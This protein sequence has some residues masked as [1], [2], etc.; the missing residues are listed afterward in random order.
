MTTL[1][2][3]KAVAAFDKVK[4]A[5]D[6]LRSEYGQID[7]AIAK[8][9]T[10]MAALPQM[11]VPFEDMKQGILELIDTAGKR[12]AEEHIKPALMRFATGGMGS[13]GSGVNEYGKPLTLA[14]LEGAVRGSLFPE[15]RAQLVHPDKNQFD[16]LAFYALCADAVKATLS[17]LLDSITPDDFGYLTIHPDKIGPTRSEMRRRMADW[18]QQLEDLKARRVDILSQLAQL[19][20]NVA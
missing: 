19:G 12:Y 10:D 14:A 18:Q 6:A 4:Q 2:H 15:A 11:R 3:A 16:D 5:V 1:N 20:V 8:L 9:E 13:L 17:R 7:E